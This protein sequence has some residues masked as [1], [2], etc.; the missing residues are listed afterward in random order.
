[1]LNSDLAIF[2]KVYY[3]QEE[4]L[5]DF[6]RP[7]IVDKEGLNKKLNQQKITHFWGGFPR[8]DYLTVD[9]KTFE[10]GM[11][12]IRYKN[13]TSLVSFVIELFVK[14]TKSTTPE[15]ELQTMNAELE[16]KLLLNE[17]KERGKENLSKHLDLQSRTKEAEFPLFH[18]RSSIF[19]FFLRKVNLKMIKNGEV[20]YIISIRDFCKKDEFESNGRVEQSY[21]VGKLSVCHLKTESG[22]KLELLR[23]VSIDSK[24]EL[25]EQLHENMI[26]VNRVYYYVEGIS[27][28]NKWEIVKN[29]EIFFAPMA[30]N[31]TQN[32]YDFMIEFFYTNEADKG[33]KNTFVRKDEMETIKLQVKFRNL[34]DRESRTL[35]QDEQALS[36]RTSQDHY[37]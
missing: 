32:L 16:S 6:A 25:L 35:L 23:R 17:L 3:Q 13:F 28:V 15:D 18:S 1:M 34:D 26:F 21:S 19:E 20:H 9:V 27:H 29:F 10:S 33:G 4:Y 8:T 30:I 11:D 22:E 31:L 2:T 5:I 36:Q 7:F 24:C 37:Q 14:Q 12:S